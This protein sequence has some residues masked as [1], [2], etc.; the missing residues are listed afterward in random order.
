MARN[1]VAVAAVAAVLAMTAHVAVADESGTF[2]MLRSYQHT[3]VTIDHGAES[4]TGGI[5]K[6][7]ETII[8]S[9]GGPFVEGVNSVSEC[10]VFSRSSNGSISLQAPCVNVDG[11]GD[12]LY[13]VALREQ[14]SISAAGGGGGRWELRGGT[15]KYEGV[16]GDCTYQT[17]YLEGGW[18]VLVSDCKWSSS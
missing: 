13:S 2:R 12:Q 14:G 10:L 8:S 16:T 3:Y 6:G 4:Y 15:G 7:T 9:S 5:L 17:Q 11:S 18:A 1:K